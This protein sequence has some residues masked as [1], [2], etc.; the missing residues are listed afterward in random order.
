MEDARAEIRNLNKQ[1]RAA[2]REMALERLI[3]KEI[4]TVDRR[5]NKNAR[6]TCKDMA[7]LVLAGII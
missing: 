3:E 4:I 7:D 5:K 2:E 6:L 1:N